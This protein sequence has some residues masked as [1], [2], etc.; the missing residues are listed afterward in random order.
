[1]FALLSHGVF[2]AALSP[3][4]C[5]MGVRTGAREGLSVERQCAGSSSHAAADMLAPPA[6]VEEG[7]VAIAEKWK[8]GDHVWQKE[9]SSAEGEPVG[10]VDGERR[11]SSAGGIRQRGARGTVAT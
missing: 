6:G 1:M 7:H 2:P 8:D 4:P 10:A 5:T 11:A 3:C 9:S